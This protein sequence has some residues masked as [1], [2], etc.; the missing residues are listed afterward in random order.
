MKTVHQD[1]EQRDK[2]RDLSN[3][4]NFGPAKALVHRFSK[5]NMRN[6]R[7][8]LPPD[9]RLKVGQDPSP[10]VPLEATQESP[11]KI[12]IVHAGV[13]PGANVSE[14]NGYFGYGLTDRSNSDHYNVNT[15][16]PNAAIQ[17]VGNSVE[18]TLEM[19]SFQDGRH[20]LSVDENQNSAVD[21]ASLIT[22][23][24]QEFTVPSSEPPRRRK[25]QFVNEIDENSH[26]VEFGG[27]SAIAAAEFGA[28]D[29]KGAMFE[30]EETSFVVQNEPV[31]G[32]SRGDVDSL[33][34]SSRSASI[35][36]SPGRDNRGSIDSTLQ[37]Q[38]L[39][40]KRRY[41]E[42]LDPVTKVHD[43][44]EARTGTLPPID[45]TSSWASSAPVPRVQSPVSPPRSEVGASV[46]SMNEQATSWASS[47]AKDRPVSAKTK[48]SDETDS[49]LSEDDMALEN[50]DFS[51]DTFSVSEESEPY[52]QEQ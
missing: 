1:T 50:C 52:R 22:A 34:L 44:N 15:V 45:S 16:L 33:T 10:G 3:K 8:I 51:S 27:P 18:E 24:S 5:A 2:L 37:A 31:P 4:K 23:Y 28:Y 41:S 29:N 21:S 47:V 26:G 12:V 46:P 11:T 43:E 7:S 13:E 20:L 6:S 42:D 40:E 36:V 14:K 17:Y 39:L 25:K 30:G 35:A 49:A 19:M 48:W 9:P 38:P 32:T